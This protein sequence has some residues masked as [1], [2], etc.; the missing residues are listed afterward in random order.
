MEL[1]LLVAGRLFLTHK[2]LMI[3]DI[4]GAKHRWIFECTSC[5]KRFLNHKAITI[6]DILPSEYF[7][8]ILF[9]L[10]QNNPYTVKS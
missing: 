8:V 10:L 9:F 4:Q 3:F 1:R 6:E 7:Y 5:S 2:S